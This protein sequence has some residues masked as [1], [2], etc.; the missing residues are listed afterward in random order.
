MSF[1]TL[2]PAT[3]QKAVEAA[4][5][6]ESEFNGS[7]CV[8]ATD[9]SKVL[10]TPYLNLEAYSDKE[11]GAVTF[12]VSSIRLS[13]EGLT[14][15]DEYL[16][17]TTR[18]N[19]KVVTVSIHNDCIL[20]IY[21]MTDP[22]TAGKIIAEKASTKPSPKFTNPAKFVLIRD[23]CKVFPD[24]LINIT[25]TADGLRSTCPAVID[26]GAIIQ[27]ILED[28]EATRLA[29][30]TDVENILDESQMGLY[31]VHDADTDS[32]TAC[33]IELLSVIMTN[34]TH[35]RVLFVGDCTN[36]TFLDKETQDKMI[37]YQMKL[38]SQE[39]SPELDE[40]IQNP[41]SFGENVVSLSRFRA[42]R[43]KRA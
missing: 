12:N 35:D 28:G 26:D 18:F 11:S 33:A 27:V 5:R 19:G 34:P 36:F 1:I 24:N 17:F 40:V 30:M 14:G 3:V 13:P 31:L 4:L 37:D 25:F 29:F 32:Q 16:T 10:T 43:G 42:S 20:G 15:D 6:I 21:D 9:W 2:K 38:T 41:E 8:I 22:A 7:P 23:L 39:S